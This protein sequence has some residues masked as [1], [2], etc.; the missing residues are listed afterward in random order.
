MANNVWRHSANTAV[1]QVRTFT[2]TAAGASGIIWTFTITDD[3]GTTYTGVT[4]TNDASPT[5]TEVASGLTSAWNSSTNP[6]ALRITASNPSDSVV[7]LTSDTAGI[8][9]TVTLADDGA[10]THTETATTANVGNED[11]SL[12]LNWSLDTVPTATNDLIFEPGSVNWK[13][14]LNQSSVAIADFRAMKGC[15]SQFGRFE[16]GKFYYLRIDPDAYDFRGNG[17]LCLF[18]IGSANISPY[19]EAHGSPSATG[20]HTVYIKGSNIATL[21]AAKGNVGISVLDADTTTVATVLCGLLENQTSDV[22]MTIGSGTTL[23]TLTQYGGKCLLKCA[24]TTVNIYKGGILTTEGTGAITTVNVYEGATFY[25]KSTGT[26]TTLNLWGTAD[27]SRHVGAKT[28]TTLN[29]KKGGTIIKHDA[30]T[31]TTFNGPS[32]SGGSIDT[33]KAA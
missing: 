9:F 7:K 17:N 23:T 32:S 27:F 15:S 24:G 30:I 16:F 8:P 25:A 12:A 3:D 21:T 26:I 4:Y 6:L 19:I 22:D 14:G 28:V 10:G 33:I 13:Y 31:I 1:A 2:I 20:R 29:L 11:G 5:T 18:D